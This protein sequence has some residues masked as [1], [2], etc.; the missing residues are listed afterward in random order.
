[1]KKIWRYLILLIVLLAIPLVVLILTSK[2]KS[3]EGKIESLRSERYWVREEMALP[4]LSFQEVQYEIK[5]IKVR[6]KKGKV[7][8]LAIW[9]WHDSLT[10]ESI[11]KFIKGSYRTGNLLEIKGENVIFGFIDLPGPKIKLKGKPTGVIK[12]YEIIHNPYSRD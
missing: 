5:R 12:K 10:S 1:M 4:F 9:D 2:S 6:T 7:L 11:G 8:E 3:F